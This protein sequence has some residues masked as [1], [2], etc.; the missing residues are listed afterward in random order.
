MLH[1][2]LAQVITT[3]IL[4][5]LGHL[6][7]IAIYLFGSRAKNEERP[8][9]DIDLAVLLPQGLSLNYLDRLC[10]IDELQDIAKCRVDL[11]AVNQ[12]NIPL[13]FEI[14]HSGKVLFEADFDARTD[15]EDIIL[16]DYFDLEPMYRQN[17]QEIME[18]VLG[19][20]GWVI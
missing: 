2:N 12:V 17:Y 10:L 18:D 8:D 9:S 16:R 19:K 13:K 1:S 7:P 11:V 3:K 14:V 4:E 6:N 5:Q 15:A 20:K